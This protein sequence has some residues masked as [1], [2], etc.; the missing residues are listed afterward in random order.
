MTAPC[1]DCSERHVGCHSTCLKYKAFATRCK[2]IN[3]HRK[4]EAVNCYYASEYC[5]EKAIFHSYGYGN[6]SKKHL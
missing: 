6:D 5:R 2:Q 3:D 4:Q 1:K